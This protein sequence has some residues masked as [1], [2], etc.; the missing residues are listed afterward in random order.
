MCGPRNAKFLGPPVR[1]QSLY[2]AET[3]I[4][5]LISNAELLHDAGNVTA[6]AVS[7]AGIA[8]ERRPS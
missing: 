3:Y 8:D 1:P 4:G 5:A 7:S 2:R 6:S